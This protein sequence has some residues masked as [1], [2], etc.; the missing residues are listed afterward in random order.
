M[1]S[2]SL[3][4]LKKTSPAKVQVLENVL[5]NPSMD[6]S[7]MPPLIT[8]PVGYEEFPG[9]P[10]EENGQIFPVNY[11]QSVDWDDVASIISCSQP[12]TEVEAASSI[13]KGRGKD[14]K[15]L[16]VEQSVTQNSESDEDDDFVGIVSQHEK[17]FITNIKKTY[18]KVKREYDSV[19]KEYGAVKAEAKKIKAQ[20]DAIEQKE[21]LLRLKRNKSLY[22]IRK[23]TDFS[24]KLGFSL[25]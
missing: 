3:L 13:G 9:P 7:T 19:Q 25:E 12:P 5:I 20:L 6:S 15:K 2:R 18:K 10:C 17:V 1:T 11:E 16:I 23:C 22:D 14:M 4:S 24:K 21:K 8:I